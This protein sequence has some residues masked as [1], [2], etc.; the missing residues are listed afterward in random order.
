MDDTV[1]LP[2]ADLLERVETTVAGAAMALLVLGIFVDVFFRQVVSY[3]IM[4]LQEVSMFSFMWLTFIGAAVA[5]RRNSHYRIELIP[6]LVKSPRVLMIVQVAVVLIG[7][8]FALILAYQG[9]GFA[10]MGIKRVSRPSGI[11]LVYVFV[12]LP[13]CGLS[14]CYF[15]IER[16]L[17]IRAEGR[18]G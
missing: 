8:A 12:T 1:K 13:I 6:M 9:F 4:W 10:E 7:L 16:F 17:R 14:M 3:P 11:P 5:V 15:L 18:R 2:A